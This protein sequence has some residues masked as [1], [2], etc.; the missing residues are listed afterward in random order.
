[1]A[2]PDKYVRYFDEKTRL[3]HVWP[4]GTPIPV[5]IQPSGPRHPKAADLDEVFRKSAPRPEEAADGEL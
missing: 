1:M 5:T 4:R 2:H 3:L